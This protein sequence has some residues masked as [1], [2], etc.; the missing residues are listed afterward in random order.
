MAL[1]SEVKLELKKGANKMAIPL[2]IAGVR[3]AAPV[4]AKYLAGKISRQAAIKAS[5]ELA[6]KP[7]KSILQ[8]GKE[9]V[10]GKPYQKEGKT[11]IDKQISKI[12]KKNIG[13]NTKELAKDAGRFYVGDKAFDASL[14][15]INRMKKGG[16]VKK[17]RMDGIALRGKTRAKERSK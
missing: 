4:A 1:P 16:M 2:I 5:K 14:D 3:I 12:N 15:A 6:K 13:P 8:K 7:A 10:L 11:F 9:V 17:C